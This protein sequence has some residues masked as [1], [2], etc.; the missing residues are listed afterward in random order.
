MIKKWHIVLISVATVL[1]CIPLFVFAI[2]V[3]APPTEK[4]KASPL[5]MAVNESGRCVLHRCTKAPMYSSGV[6][7]ITTDCC[8]TKIQCSALRVVTYND[9][10]LYLLKFV[11]ICGE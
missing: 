1:L 5:Y 8:K 10:P 11:D 7:Y 2:N 6:A 9:K 3:F 4:V